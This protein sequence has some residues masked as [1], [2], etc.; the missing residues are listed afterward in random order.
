MNRVT[1]QALRF[2][3]T[4]GLL[5]PAHIDEENGYRYYTMS[6]M[7]VVHQITALKQAGFT[8]EDIARI[9]AG[10]DKDVFLLHIASICWKYSRNYKQ[11]VV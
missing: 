1:V 9:N 8:L 4:Q 11:I 10:D 7:A 2:Y 5:M 3:E 6:Q